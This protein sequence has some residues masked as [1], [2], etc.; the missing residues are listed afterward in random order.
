MKLMIA[1]VLCALVLLG[2]EANPVQDAKVDVGGYKLQFH[3]VPGKSPTIVFESGGGNDSS[4][5]R[6]IV[7]AVA[8][9]TGARLITYDRAGYG[10]SDPAPGPYSITQEVEALERGLKQLQVDTDLIVVAH[11]YGGFLAT[12]FAARNSSTVKGLVLIDANLAPFFTDAVVKQLTVLQHGVLEQAKKENPRTGA[13][14]ERLLAAFPE[15]VRMMRE[16]TFPPTMRVT[17]IVSEKPLV[18]RPN[19]E[20]G[21]GGAAWLRAHQ[22]FDK[23]APNRRGLV[24][25][26]SGHIVMRDRPDLVV[27]EIAAMVFGAR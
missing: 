1:G 8:S 7:P 15:T 25:K 19:E 21:P 10:Q 22:E 6:Q 20:I 13:S 23:A 18:P 16:V 27:D 26:D 9:R 11:S 17:D 24:A 12:L 5:W 14:I 4:A 3:I 2:Q